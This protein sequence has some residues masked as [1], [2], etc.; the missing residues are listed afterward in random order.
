[1]ILFF[2]GLKPSSRINSRPTSLLQSLRGEGGTSQYFHSTRND[3]FATEESPKH[4][5][6]PSGFLPSIHPSPNPNFA[7]EEYLNSKPMSI[8]TKR[9][10]SSPKFSGTVTMNTSA[11]NFRQEFQVSQYHGGD[12]RHSWARGT[13]YSQTHNSELGK[14][15][16]NAHQIFIVVVCRETR[17]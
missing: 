3:T 16:S 2:L 9:T 15:D 14:L 6:S 5:R 1:V 10:E 13:H 11:A 17:Y 7:V 8:Q 12:I 4:E